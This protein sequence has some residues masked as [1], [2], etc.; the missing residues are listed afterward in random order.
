MSRT[1]PRGCTFSMKCFEHKTTAAAPSVICEQ[2]LTLSGVAMGRSMSLVVQARS[3]C[4]LVVADLGERVQP[5]VCA[6]F[7]PNKSSPASQS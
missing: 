3:K 5:R 6:T 4:E 1:D 2:S 7:R